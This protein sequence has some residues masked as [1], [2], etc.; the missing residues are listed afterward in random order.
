MGT[1]H[2]FGNRNL[3]AVCPRLGHRG[4]HHKE[5]AQARPRVPMHLFKQ[6]CNNRHIA[7]RFAGGNG[8]RGGRDGKR[9]RSH[10]SGVHRAHIQHTC[11]HIALG[12]PRSRTGFRRRPDGGGRRACR[13]APKA[14][15]RRKARGAQHSC[16]PY[17]TRHC[18]GACGNRSA[19]RRNCHLGQRG[20]HAGRRPHLYI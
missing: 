7:C 1:R 19:L 15:G 18:C 13:T 2:L 3:R 16:Q 20:V 17:D 5:C 12:V 9:R 4:A 11:R 6:L 8:A 10:N 14:E